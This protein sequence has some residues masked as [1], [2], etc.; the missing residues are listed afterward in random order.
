MESGGYVRF[1]VDTGAQ[2]NLLPLDTYK[3]ATGDI[4]LKGNKSSP[5]VTTYGG[6]ALPV[7]GTVLLKVWREGSKYRLDCKLVDS[8]KIRHLLGR[9]ACLGTR[10]IT[11]LD[12][13][14]IRKPISR[15]APVYALEDHRPVTIEQLM[16]EHPAVFEPGVGQLEGEYRILLD[17]SVPPV[18]HPPCRVPVPL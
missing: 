10:I 8:P 3:K 1:H 5:K 2:C 7:A 12:N 16:M 4:S 15:G 18:Q 14:D 13:D 9:K 11:Y 17:K 6:G